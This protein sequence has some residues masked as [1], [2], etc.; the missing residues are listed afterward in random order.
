VESVEEEKKV[1]IDVKLNNL[2]SLPQE[3][4]KTGQRR[5]MIEEEK[6]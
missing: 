4:K 3:E 1:V 2:L 6:K 5:V